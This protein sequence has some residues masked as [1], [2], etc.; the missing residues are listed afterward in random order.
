MERPKYAT[1]ALAII[2]YDKQNGMEGMRNDVAV[3]R[4]HLKKE[5]QF[6]IT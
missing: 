2:T 6:I 5:K 3:M 4:R 1:S